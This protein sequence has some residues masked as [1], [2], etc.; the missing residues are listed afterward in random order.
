MFMTL[1]DILRQKSTEIYMTS[2]TETVS[3]A[4]SAMADKGIGAL[5]VIEDKQLRGI[6]TERDIVN[7]LLKNHLPPDTTRVSEIMTTQLIFAH[8][9]TT[10]ASAM[11]TFT[12]HRF[13]HLPV[14]ENH[15]LLGMVS[16][17]DVTKWL[18]NNQ[19]EEISYL[20]DYIRTAG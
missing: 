6:V 14:I 11:A 7:K 17:G 1:G 9:S 4:A 5:L 16:I 2:P 10:I 15:A 8:P 12:Q 19:Q 3:N 20:T 13:R 18:L